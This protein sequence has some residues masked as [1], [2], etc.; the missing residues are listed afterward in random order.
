MITP[1]R[2]GLIGPGRIAHRFAQA[3]QRRGGVLQ[4]VVGRN[5]ERA[6]AFAARWGAQVRPSVDALLADDSIEAIYIATPHSDHAGSAAAALRAGK[7]VLCE[8]PLAATAAQAESLVALA[9][10]HKVFLMEAL[11]TR[12]LP[13]LRQ[14]ERWLQDGRIGRV[15]NV[16]SSFGFHLP[17]DAAH[18]CFNAALAGGALLDIGI[19]NLSLSQWALALQGVHAAPTMQATGHLAPSGVELRCAVQMRYA[20]G[21]LSQFT[22]GFDAHDRNTLCLH[23]ERGVIELGPNFWQATQAQLRLHG[24]EPDTVPAPFEVNGFEYQIDA[25]TAAI[26]AGL[27][28]EPRMLHAQT[29]AVLQQIDALRQ[30]LGAVKFPFE[31]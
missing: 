12:Y 8:K 7:P 18:R 28:E 9:R 14:A 26:R 27:I 31:P 17:F 15:S 20:D 29:L 10:R 22:C 4:A 24:A 5:P 25:A 16:Q 19:Y 1:L 3:L 11:W 21:T 6:Q 23:G 30:A 2:W 13:A